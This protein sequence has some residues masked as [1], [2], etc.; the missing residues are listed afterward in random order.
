V[1]NLPG[2]LSDEKRGGGARCATRECRNGADGGSG[3]GG[4]GGGGGGRWCITDNG[5]NCATLFR[6]AY[7]VS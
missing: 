1:Q 6:C 5:R 3:G 7:C 2:T 4:G